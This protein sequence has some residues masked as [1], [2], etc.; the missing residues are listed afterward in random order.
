MLLTIMHDNASPDSI[1]PKPRV[2]AG[3]AR[4]T[5]MGL[6]IVSSSGSDMAGERRRSCYQLG[7]FL[8]N[9]SEPVL[10]LSVW[11]ETQDLHENCF[12]R[13]MAMCIVGSLFFSQSPQ[14][15]PGVLQCYTRKGKIC[16]STLG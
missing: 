3:R 2:S 14:S 7:L 16:E 6:S 12:E 8:G 11:T 5:R 1:T 4:N 10:I 13:S 15:S 9:L